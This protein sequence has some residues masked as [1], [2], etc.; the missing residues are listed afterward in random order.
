MDKILTF[1]SFRKI[2]K[3]S[4]LVDFIINNHP[5]KNTNKYKTRK[6]EE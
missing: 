2:I 3:L 1:T 6:E 4:M 5:I